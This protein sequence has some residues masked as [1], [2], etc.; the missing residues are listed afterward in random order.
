MIQITNIEKYTVQYIEKASKDEAPQQ[1]PAEQMHQ[2]RQHT[3]ITRNT[4]NS[5][6]SRINNILQSSKTNNNSNQENSGDDHK[7]ESNIHGENAS[8]LDSATISLNKVNS[9]EINSATSQSSQTKKYIG[10]RCN[11]LVII[12]AE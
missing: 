12:H 10:S 7:I 11:I 4:K 3:N 8:N 2:A 9:S 5:V 1:Q 6:L